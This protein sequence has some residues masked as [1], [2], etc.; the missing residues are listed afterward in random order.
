MERA[1]LHKP[2]MKQVSGGLSLNPAWTCLE[3]Y[4]AGRSRQPGWQQ[5]GR[6]ARG[7][8]LVTAD[9]HGPATYVV[10]SG[11]AVTDPK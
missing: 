3:V 8:Y 1:A 4:N 9:D 11:R 7:L 5:A 10:W 6:K 2:E